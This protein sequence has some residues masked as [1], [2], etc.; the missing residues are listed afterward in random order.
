MNN[1]TPITYTHKREV[2]SRLIWV[3][4]SIGDALEIM[5]HDG[6][7]IRI[8][9]ATMP[10][11]RIGSGSRPSGIEKYIRDVIGLPVDC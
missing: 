11:I 6:K 4:P 2:G 7:C 3:Y 10:P 9:I 8:A 5:E 1:N